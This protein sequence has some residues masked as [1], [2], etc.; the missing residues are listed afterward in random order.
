[1]QIDKAA[2]LAL[3]LFAVAAAS[4]DGM[5]ES[6]VRDEHDDDAATASV[7]GGAPAS[8]RDSGGGAGADASE[9][10]GVDAG[11]VVEPDAGGPVIERDAGARTTGT[12]LGA[13]P[14]YEP[15]SGAPALAIHRYGS[16]GEPIADLLAEATVI[17]LRLRAKPT[18]QVTTSTFQPVLDGMYDAQIDARAAE[19]RARAGRVYLV[20]FHH[21][22]LDIEFLPEELTRD[23]RRIWAR[24]FEHAID[25]FAAAGVTNVRWTSCIMG[26]QYAT[27]GGE[28]YHTPSLLSKLYAVGADVYLDPGSRD[29]NTHR[30]WQAFARYEPTMRHAI[31]EWALRD[32]PDDQGTTYQAVYDWV[33]ANPNYVAL[34]GWNVM[35]SGHDDSLSPS[36]IEVYERMAAD[37]YFTR[38]VVP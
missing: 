37:P 30:A 11:P 14:L 22:P 33:K 12:L 3:A 8:G 15:A 2:L 21:E 16:W 19:F 31:L 4:C 9:G 20:T 10:L 17:N 18:A 5:T 23:E 27:H 7:D 6:G 24:A 36:G 13:S 29:P 25:R 35:W 26:S 32:D 28:T 34:V 1:M 38:S